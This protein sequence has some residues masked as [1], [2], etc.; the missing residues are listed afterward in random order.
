MRCGISAHVPNNPDSR[1]FAQFADVSKTERIDFISKSRKIEDKVTGADSAGGQHDHRLVQRWKDSTYMLFQL[2]EMG[3]SVV[4]L[5]FNSHFGRGAAIS[6]C[7]SF[8]RIEHIMLQPESFKAVI[9]QSIDRHAT[10]CK[11]CFKGLL[12]GALQ[13][14]G[15]RRIPYI[16][17]GL[18]RGQ[19][20]EERLQWFYERHVFDPDEIDAQLKR[21]RLVYHQKEYFAGNPYWSAELGSLAEQ[22][23]LIDYYRFDPV[24]R[25][26]IVDFLHTRP[27]IWKQ[28]TDCGFCSTNCLVNDVASA[29]IR[30]K[31]VG[32][33]DRPR[34]TSAR[35]SKP[36]SGGRGSRMWSISNV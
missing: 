32:N 4:T 29:F 34:G 36:W 24:A 25:V 31:R 11:G 14:A 12:D 28:P 18:S 23:E 22:V 15:D 17:T 33:R 35:P 1:T 19:I 3:L 13:V 6:C 30:S 2:I 9:N 27:D 21:G 16:V 8:A 26:G 20:V 5:T 10:P 7:R